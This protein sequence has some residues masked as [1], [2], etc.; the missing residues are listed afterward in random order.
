MRSETIGWVGG[1]AIIAGV[2]FTL[3]LAVQPR[4]LLRHL[5]AKYL[6]AMDARL[7][8]LFLKIDAKS[9]LG[10][11]ALA[12][13]C[14]IYLTLKVELRFAL[15]VPAILA[16]PK[17]VLSSLRKARLRAIESQLNGWLAVMANMFKV[18]GSL[19]DALAHS[20]ELVR[21]PLGQEL[22]L[23]LKELRVGA[24]LPEALRTFAQ[25]V[26]N[27]ALS[28]VVTIL[29]MGRTTGGELPTLLDETAAALR[30]RARLEG[31]VRKQTA[32]GRVQLVVLFSA[33]PIIVLMFYQ[34]DPTFFDPLTQSGVM[35]HLIIAAAASIWVGSLVM[36]R[37]IL[38]TDL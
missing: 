13:I 29:L 10:L 22:D 21:G 37:N 32:M 27:D 24:P 3:F 33:P 23:V 38:K 26:R 6:A 1:V 12:L 20:M 11:Q 36:A 18:T 25:R 8:A 28:T 2:A 34:V 15:A 5:V 14:A 16:A 19:A 4:S 17:V 31:V 30:E 9:I 35:G 7:R